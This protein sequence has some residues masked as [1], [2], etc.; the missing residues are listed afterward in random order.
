MHQ[1][2]LSQQTRRT[3]QVTLITE[4]LGKH[5]NHGAASRRHRPDRDNTLAAPITVASGRSPH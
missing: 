1:R 3:H 5:F 2:A 4:G